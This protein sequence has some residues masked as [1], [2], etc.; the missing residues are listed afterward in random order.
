MGYFVYF[1]YLNSYNTV[2]KFKRRFWFGHQSILSGFTIPWVTYM[3]LY[4]STYTFLQ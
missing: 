3:F 1:I 4:R 2:K